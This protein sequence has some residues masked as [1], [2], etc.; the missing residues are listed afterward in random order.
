MRGVLF[1]SGSATAQLN[2]KE[3]T[4]VLGR[5]SSLAGRLD[6]KAC[7]GGNHELLRFWKPIRSVLACNENLAAELSAVARLLERVN[8]L[9]FANAVLRFYPVSELMVVGAPS[10]HLCAN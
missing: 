10:V 8:P 1:Q 6:V 4:D 5:C 3:K 2:L 7:L 9:G